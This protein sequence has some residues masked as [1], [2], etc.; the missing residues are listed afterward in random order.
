[1]A[2]KLENG[3]MRWSRMTESYPRQRERERERESEN[4]REKEKG[5]IERNIGKKTI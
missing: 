5:H 3:Q 1:M 2:K 4:D